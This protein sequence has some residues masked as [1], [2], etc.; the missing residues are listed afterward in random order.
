MIRRRE[1]LVALALANP[2]TAGEMMNERHEQKVARFRQRIDFD[3]VLA[4]ESRAEAAVV[5]WPDPRMVPALGSPPWTVVSDTLWREGGGALRE[6]VLRRNRETL[7]ILAF[8]SSAGPDPARGF[9]LA[10]AAN[11]MLVDVPYVRGPQNLG[12][13]ALTAEAPTPPYF[14][15]VFRNLCL[16]VK[17]RDTAVDALAVA[18]WLQALAARSLVR[19]G[20]L[21]RAALPL[22]HVP[23]ASVVV[24]KVVSMTVQ[25]PPDATGNKYLLQVETIPAELQLLDQQPD[26][27][28]IRPLKPGSVTLQLHW[29]NSE[30]L[31]SRST[32]VAFDV[33]P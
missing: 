16:E 13:L 31:I 32:T 15:W 1:M 20:D 33:R 4:A 11:S 2:A 17:V 23:A 7:S 14:L 12:S 8:V 9:L 22:A 24:G 3:R 28:Q 21:E 25:A 6:W 26:Q 27:L 30:T 10:R 29:L 5:R 19:W 18:Q